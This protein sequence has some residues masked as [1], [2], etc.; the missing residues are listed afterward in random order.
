MSLLGCTIHNTCLMPNVISCHI[1][2]S[3]ASFLYRIDTALYIACLHPL[4]PLRIALYGLRTA[5]AHGHGKEWLYVPL[6]SDPLPVNGFFTRRNTEICA[7]AFGVRDSGLLIDYRYKYQ[8]CRTCIVLS[9][10][11]RLSSRKS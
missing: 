2:E 8:V 11:S 5:T 7:R 9:V 4:C 6:T 1:F 3:P 10:S